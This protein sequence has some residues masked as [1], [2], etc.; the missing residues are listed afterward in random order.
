MIN[1]LM[2]KVRRVGILGGGPSA[3]F[4]LK[5]WIESG[6]K[7]FSLTIFEQNDRVGSGMPYSTQGA[8]REHITN[9]S[10]NEIPKLVSSISDWIAKVPQQKLTLYGIDAEHFSEYKVLPRLLLGEYLSDQFALL[11]DQSKKMDL[12][13]KV[14]L[15]ARVTDVRENKVTEEVVVILSDG[16]QIVFDQVII[17]TGHHWS[18]VQEQKTPNYFDSPYPPSKLQLKL[19]HTVAIRGASL[20]AIDAIRTLARNNGSFVSNDDRR[21]SYKLEPGSN[22]F[23]IVMY[24]R[25]GMLPAVRFHLEDSLLSK[26]SMLTPDQVQAYREQN[27]GFLSLDYIFE[28][29]F[30]DVFRE[31]D[32]EFYQRIRDMS[33]EDF[34]ESMMELREKVDPFTFF[35]AEY[36]E[37]AK[38]IKRKESVLWKEM[39]AV[40]SFA[41]NYPAKYLSAE[42]MMRLRNVL[43]PLISIVIAFVPQS[44]CEELIALHE[45]GVLSLMSVGD[46]GEFEPHTTGA[47]FKYEVDGVQQVV[48]YNTFIDCIG[49]RH[50]SFEQFPFKSL[51]ADETVSSA[52]VRF[53]SSI[54]GEQSL[55]NNSA[56]VSR[57]DKGNYYLK[58]A[59][60]AINDNFQVVDE[61]GAFNNRIF[62]MAV[63]FIGG[64]NPD[65]SGLDFCEAASA[66]IVN[67]IVNRSEMPR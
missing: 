37:A 16:E 26:Q 6:R 34:V 40:L 45:A 59:G 43:M 56:Q 65:Y 60:I 38:S 30:K 49:Q 58:V 33:L 24:S 1:N 44:S 64:F 47:I 9:V 18:S 22:D 39:L 55:K 25:N 54:R 53:Q 32:P 2:E 48:H 27:D 42:D 36:A 11:L 66:I 67:T 10:D 4:V 12:H 62:V 57:D 19:N 35:K 23:K 63:P 15:S 8:N 28:K 52:R 51:V 13:V 29:T 7:D 41:M 50:L 20:T 17:C 61:Y 3:L 31:K 46:E 21:L 14:K 5:R